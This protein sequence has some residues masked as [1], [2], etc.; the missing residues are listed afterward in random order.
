M[1]TCRSC[2][3]RCHTESTMCLDFFVSE[4]ASVKCQCDVCHCES[5]SAQR[6]WEIH[7]KEFG[8]HGL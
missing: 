8:G 7:N 1:N 2:G 3:H 6:S 4:W 5:C